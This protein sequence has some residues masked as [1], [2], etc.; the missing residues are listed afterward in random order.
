MQREEELFTDLEKLKVYG[1]G[2][3]SVSFQQVSW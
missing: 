1:C 3:Q 2:K